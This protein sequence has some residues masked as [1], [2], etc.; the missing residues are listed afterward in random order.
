MFNIFFI[1]D[2]PKYGIHGSVANA[3]IKQYEIID[4]LLMITRGPSPVLGRTSFIINMAAID[5]MR[6]FPILK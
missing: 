1:L 2:S 3:R 6:D 5:W 4:T